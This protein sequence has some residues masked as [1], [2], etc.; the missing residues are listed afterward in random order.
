MD[1]A[2]RIA[3]RAIDKLRLLFNGNSQPS[4]ELTQT[5]NDAM[6]ADT[7]IDPNVEYTPHEFA[8]FIGV[9]FNSLV[10][11]CEEQLEEALTHA[12]CLCE[13]VSNK[14]IHDLAVYCTS[15]RQG[16]ALDPTFAFKL[17]MAI[18]VRESK[19]EVIEYAPHHIVQDV[20]VANGVFEK[21]QPKEDCT[22]D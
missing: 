13:K 21:T 8:E 1:N 19:N 5:R 9:Q 11:K 2:H 15:Y 7:L 22:D 6:S 16:A 17:V 10:L 4:E 14:F 12:R 18:A 3:E 20:L